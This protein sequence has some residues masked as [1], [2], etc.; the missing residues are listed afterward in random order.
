MPSRPMALTRLLFGTALAVAFAPAVTATPAS[1]GTC[2][3]TK[4]PLDAASKQIDRGDMLWVS[5]T[6]SVG[7]TTPAGTGTVQVDN[8]GPMPLQALLIDAEQH[9][10]RQLVVSNSRGAHPYP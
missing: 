8:A 6:G 5:H 2:G 4:P 9:A 1:A 10:I 7:I 3:Q